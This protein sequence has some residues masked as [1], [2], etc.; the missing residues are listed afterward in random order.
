MEIPGYA[1]Q[2]TIGRGGMA[3]VYVA[4]QES[5]QRE[6]VLKVLHPKQ[7]ESA[8][9][10]ERFLNE[11]RIIA[12]L[13]HPNI[14]T[15]HDVGRCDGTVYIAMEFVEGGDLKAR[16]ARHVFTP[17]EALDLVEHIASGLGLAHRRGIVHRDVKPGNILFRKDGT[18]LLSDFGIAKQLTIDDDLTKTGV[19]LG[20][21]NYMAPEQADAASVDG[22]A[23]IY[24]LGV[25]FYEMLTGQKPYLAD[26]VI[27]IIM[28]HKKAPIPQ[29]PAGLAP[30]QELLD[31]MMAKKRNDRFRDI[32]SLLH[33]IAQLRERGLDAQDSIATVEMVRKPRG[34]RVTRLPV[35]SGGVPRRQLILG[36]LLV[37]SALG[38][39]TVHILAARVENY[40]SGAASP[41]VALP[42]QALS[43]SLPPPAASSAPGTEEVVAALRWLVQH[44]LDHYRLTAPPRDNALY[45][46]R[47]LDQIEPDSPYVASG[48]AE[49]SRRFA[50]LAERELADNHVAR[51]VALCEA[52]LEIDPGNDY[53]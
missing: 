16:L 28:L 14:I 43:E 6:V 44:S 10:I 46:L 11:G 31:L 19:F 32:D 49:L 39:T 5:L 22:R 38:F 7:T 41:G 26:S 27:D 3:T 36:G 33:Y 25:I 13:R 30:L 18:P 48:R 37:L 35:E 17:H 40:D 34:T 1:I 50:E 15:I 47:R 29:L 4:L 8:S 52:G 51:A 53:L 21:P 23:D 24:S 42:G 9:A 12:G 45:Y 20:S 2:S